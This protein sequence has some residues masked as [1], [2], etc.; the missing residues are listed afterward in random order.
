M[1]CRTQEE[2]KESISPEVVLQ[3]ESE[4]FQKHTD[5]SYLPDEY[6]GMPALVDKLVKLQGL[7]IHSHLPVLKK[8]VS[9][10]TLV[11]VCNCDAWQTIS[12]LQAAHRSLLSALAPQ[13]VCPAQAPQPATPQLITGGI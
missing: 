1:R 13:Q 10:C 12:K 8:Q 9:Y 7:R 2:L 4:F 3:R 11:E 6:K 5:L